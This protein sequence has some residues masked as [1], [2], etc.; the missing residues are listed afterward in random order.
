M[1]R[2]R[3]TTSRGLEMKSRARL[4]LDLLEAKERK[5]YDE[6]DRL[7]REAILERQ[8]KISPEKFSDKKVRVV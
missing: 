5:Q 1:A 7:F 3:K 8:K 6:I 4:I 2:V